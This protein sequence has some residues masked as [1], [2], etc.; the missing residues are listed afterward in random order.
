MAGWIIHFSWMIGLEG[1]FIPSLIILTSI[2]GLIYV[3]YKTKWH[4]DDLRWL[5]APFFVTLLAIYLP[6]WNLTNISLTDSAY[7]LIQAKSFLGLMDWSPTQHELDFLL[8]PPL[9]P[10]FF[11]LEL[12]FQSETSYVKITPL[13]LLTT[14]LWQI[15]HLAERWSNPL[16][17]ALVV[18]VFLLI[19]VVRYW[20][21]M[22]YLDIP[23]AGM[24]ILTL[25]LFLLT[26]ENKA[27][28]Y[29]PL[30][31]GMAAGATFLTKYTHL[32][33]IGLAGWF[34]LK[35][36]AKFRSTQ[37]ISG[38]LIIVGPYL[39]YHFITQGDPFAAT[40]PQTSFAVKSAVGNVGEYTSIMWY[41]EFKDEITSIGVVGSLLGL[42][43][44][45]IRNKKELAEVLIFLS[46]ILIIHMFILDFG[47]GRYHTPWL[48]LGVVLI[49]VSLPESNCIPKEK[50]FVNKKNQLAALSAVTLLLVASVNFETLSDESEWSEE[51]ISWSAELL[52]FH[53]QV[54]EDVPADGIILTGHQLP[55]S[56]NTGIS[57][58]RLGPSEDPIQDSI[59]LNEATHVATTNRA[60]RYKW[61]HDFDLA[62]GHTS[63]EPQDIT[64]DNQWMGVLWV[65]N[66][67]SRLDPSQYFISEE[68][69]M[70][71][72]VLILSSTQMATIGE[73]DLEIVWIEVE[74]VNSS[75]NVLEV[76]TGNDV[77]MLDGCFSANIE[78][79]GCLFESGS[80]IQ[81]KKDHVIYA[82][83]FEIDK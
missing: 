79:G 70:T 82:W 81:A 9:V 62:I 69:R 39:L 30:L 66:D 3:M 49:S 33:I 7:H 16:Q 11:S 42:I 18:P 44:L 14:T 5:L 31:L 37:F 77:Y 13:L 43:T 54:V 34:L 59:L 56:L 67:I 83:S 36:K 68:G 45:Y 57:A 61:E 8:R 10:G 50:W 73:S 52:E 75:R 63:I 21:Q 28:K 29:S 64:I 80:I 51:Y 20:G 72:D 19:P 41:N 12:L 26:E 74:K 17:A 55:I 76:L 78:N 23:V 40:F 35:D 15:Q 58:Y 38:W 27:S 47:T 25:H 48:A 65:V 46:P 22:A 53:L 6:W 2:I 71:G 32:Y 1:V 60:P 24:W 4:I